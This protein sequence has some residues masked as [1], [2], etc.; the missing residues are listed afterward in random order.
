MKQTLFNKLT[1]L[2]LAALLAISFVAPVYAATFTLSTAA[3]NAMLDAITAQVGNAGTLKYY[4]ATQPA[5]C[6]A[7]TS[8]TLLATQTLGS[9]FA[10]AASGGVLTITAPANVAAAATG[11]ATWA[12]IATSG[13]TCV[14][15]ATVT[16]TGGGGYF[17]F[18]SPSFTSGVTVTTN[19]STIN[20]PNP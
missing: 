19:A 7:I 15:D 13:G 4:T 17:T 3:R 20:A 14:M 8:Q 18:N 10:A 12:R 16:A 2:A 9:P 5:T 6:S 11:T 1:S